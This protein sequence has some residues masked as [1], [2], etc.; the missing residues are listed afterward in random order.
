MLKSVVGTWWVWRR[1][2]V[3]VIV[4]VDCPPSSRFLFWVPPEAPLSK[5]GKCFRRGN[6]CA[7]RIDV[8]ALSKTPGCAVVVVVV[9]VVI[10]NG[11]RVFFFCIFFIEQQCDFRTNDAKCQHRARTRSPLL[12]Q[13]AVSWSQESSSRFQLF[14]ASPAPFLNCP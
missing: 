10:V 8:N 1:V 11:L 5:C 14:R 2:W 3:K 4:T 13:T 6:T 12:A 7:I 9:V